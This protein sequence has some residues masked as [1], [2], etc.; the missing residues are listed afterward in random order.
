MNIRKHIASLFVLPVAMAGCASSSGSRQAEE[1]AGQEAAI[2]VLFNADSAYSFVARQCSFGERVPNTKSHS[3]CGD[4]LA[5]ELRRHGAEVTEQYASLKAFDGTVLAARNIIGEFYPEKEKRVLLLAH[6]DCRPWADNDPDPANRRKPVMGANDG[7]SGTGVLLEIA[8]LLKTHEPEVGVDILL[9]DAE[10]WG[11]QDGS[12]ESSWALGAQHWAKNVHREG[13]RKPSYGIL[14]DMV[15]DENAAFRKEYFSMQFA[16]GI[17]ENIW[18]TAARLGYG[19]R[20]LNE[21]GGAI[22]DD[23]LFINAAGIPCVDI[24]DQRTD[25]Q[26]GFFPQWHTDDDRM[27]HISRSTLEAVGHTVVSLLLEK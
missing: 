12:D 6:W 7:A 1:S 17:V 11:E 20:F 21:P 13:Y 16:P 22:T 9:L 8:R 10:D 14:L 27:D 15:G 3:D 2:P 25:T 23:H 24:I 4:Y 19:N 26:T 18:K 5:A